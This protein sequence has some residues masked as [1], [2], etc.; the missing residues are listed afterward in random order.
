MLGR[1]IDQIL[2][3]PSDPR[4]F[5]PCVRSAIDY[6]QLAERASGS[7]PRGVEFNYVWGDATEIWSRQRP[8][9]RIINLE[10]AITASQD[11]NPDKHIHYRMHPANVPCLTTAKI[12]CCVLANNHVLDWGPRGLEDT[13]SVLHAAGIKTVGAGRNQDEASSPAV[14]AIPHGRLLVY[15]FALSSSGVPGAWG[16]T[17]VGAG[18]NWLADPSTRYAE[19]VRQRI[20]RDRR[21]GDLV[22]VSVHW[23]GNWGYGISRS[24]RDFAHHLIDSA[25]V[26]LVHGHSS[27]HPKGIEVYRGKTVLYGCG[28]L[29]NDYEGIQGYDS[30]RPEL[31]LMY[32]PVIDTRSGQLAALT[33]APVRMRRFQLQRASAEETAWLAA[34]MDRECRR[35]GARVVEHRN[36]ALVVDLAVPC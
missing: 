5:E 20:E 34:I 8:D 15:G 27:H 2:P 23:G 32:F 29:L 33:L 6:V 11:A 18:V 26:D 9:V 28:D 12:D 7:I 16:A 17:P 21:A 35:L 30:F 4:L 1:G 14:I 31:A 22:I 3:H 13:L 19:A 25:R 10:T 24:E 36:G